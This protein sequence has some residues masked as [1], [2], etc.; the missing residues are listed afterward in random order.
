MRLDSQSVSSY[1]REMQI[2]TMPQQAKIVF[3]HEAMYDGVRQAILGEKK[4]IRERLNEV[5][6][7]LVQLMSVIRTD[8]EETELKQNL[9]L[10]YDYL[11]VKLESEDIVSMNEAQDILSIL[12]ETFEKLIKKRE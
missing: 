4:D 6:N 3:L 5:Q 12:N 7:I 11:Y 9:L 10:L 8:E 1:Y 2:K